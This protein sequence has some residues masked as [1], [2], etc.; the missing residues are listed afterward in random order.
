MGYLLPFAFAAADPD[1][2]TIAS[3]TVTSLKDNIIGVLTANIGLIAVI[4]GGII[5][6]L[7][8]YKLVKRVTGR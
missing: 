1:V 3:T 7:L 2:L 6:V 8:L 4:A 5:G